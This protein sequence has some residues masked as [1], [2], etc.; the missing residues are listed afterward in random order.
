M[1]P[2][3]N[4]K[5]AHTHHQGTCGPPPRM[6]KRHTRG[7]RKTIQED[8]ANRMIECVQPFAYGHN[9]VLW[10][11]VDKSRSVG[12][13]RRATVEH[14]RSCP[15]RDGSQCAGSAS[16]QK[17][18]SREGQAACTGICSVARGN[19]FPGIC[20]RSRSVYRPNSDR[21][22]RMIPSGTKR[23]WRCVHANERK[24]WDELRTWDQARSDSSPPPRLSAYPPEQLR[25]APPPQLSLPPP[26]RLSPT[27]LC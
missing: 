12:F 1:W 2:S 27:R 18:S 24:I 11:R 25:A 20:S 4:A 15:W 16:T 7:C 3:A 5:E 17:Q 13:V 19:Y 6:W 22:S 14:I 10:E 9:Q 23:G 21:R 8:R 26:P